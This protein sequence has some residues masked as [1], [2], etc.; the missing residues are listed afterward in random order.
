VEGAKQGRRPRPGTVHLA[1]AD[2]H[3]RLR[4]GCFEVSD[5]APVDHQRPSGDLLLTSL[6]NEL[7]PRALALVLTGMGEDGARGLLAVRRA[8]GYTLVEDAS[9]AVVYGMPA[10]AVT[11]GAA[12]E[13][14]PLPALAPRILELA[15]SGA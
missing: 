9:T 10:A 8:G 7:G 3:L 12:C 13:S 15:R 4:G 14:L 2:A 6:A 11:L 1:P 5:G